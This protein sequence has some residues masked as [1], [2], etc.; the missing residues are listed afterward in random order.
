MPLKI[1]N[2][3]AKDFIKTPFK[4]VKKKNSFNG[5][6]KKEL[7]AYIYTQTA[8][9]NKQTW[10]VTM[11]RYVLMRHRLQPERMCIYTQEYVIIL[12]S[13]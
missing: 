7:A 2:E 13:F 9:L 5:Y 10:Y 4:V 11:S 8:S 3:L 6:K 12:Y 1:I